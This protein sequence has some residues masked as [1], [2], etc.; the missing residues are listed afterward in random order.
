MVRRAT[1]TFGL[2]FT[3]LG[4]AFTSMPRESCAEQSAVDH[5]RDVQS[6]VNPRKQ[7]GLSQFARVGSEPLEQHSN[8]F[9]GIA[10][11]ARISAA[12]CILFFVPLTSA[13]VSHARG[14]HIHPHAKVARAGMKAARTSVVVA[15]ASKEDQHHHS[16]DDEATPGEP[17]RV[18]SKV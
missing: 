16:I 4:S 15:I 9:S 5:V 13:E 7:S 1:L 11:I 6:H 18:G 17:E 2:G 8:P 3:F 12:I 10:L 14:V